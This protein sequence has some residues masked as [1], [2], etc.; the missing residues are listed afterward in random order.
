LRGYLIN[1][2][3]S[4]KDAPKTW[5]TP[6]GSP[7]RRRF[8]GVA[9]NSFLLEPVSCSRCATAVNPPPPFS[10]AASPSQSRKVDLSLGIGILFLPFVFSWF[11]LRKGHTPLARTVSFVWL[12]VVVFTMGLGREEQ[13]FAKTNQ[14]TSMSSTDQSD[15]SA[16]VE[17]SQTAWV[18]DAYVSP[19]HM[20][21]G[22]LRTEK[23][24]SSP[25]IGTW[26][27]AALAKHGSS[28]TWVRFVDIEA[29]AYQGSPP[30]QAE[31]SKFRCK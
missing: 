22:V 28:L 17:L 31:I 25:M 26:V 10:A 9:A 24:W 15:Q 3:F 1:S 29:I 5:V 18:R 27:C 7:P 13:R 11:T 2:S 30:R 19:G 16:K 4:R 12:A 8:V 14:P 6:R 23:D 21:V 20:N